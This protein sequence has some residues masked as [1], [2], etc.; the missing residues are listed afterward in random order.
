MSD[1]IQQ[2]KEVNRRLG[3]VITLLLRSSLSND[4]AVS[5]RILI[6]EMQKLGLRPFEIANILGKTPTY[7]NK[8]LAMVKQMKSRSQKNA[9][10]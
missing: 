2:L 3:V 8:E 4:S 5:Q 9:K 7:I 10:Q 6:T 1:E